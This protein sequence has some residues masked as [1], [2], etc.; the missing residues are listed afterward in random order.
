MA[1]VALRKTADEGASKNPR[2]D[3]VIKDNSYI[4]DILDSVATNEEAIGLTKTIDSIL[5][6][7][8][9]HVKGWQSNRE[10]NRKDDQEDGNEVDVA[11]GKQESKVL[12]LAWNKKEDVLK[13][14]ELWQQGLDWDHEL[15]QSDQ[16]KWLTYFKEMDQLNEISLKRCLCPVV[17][18]EPPILCAFA[19][20]SR[21]A[22]GTCAY[23]RSIGPTG[24][25]NVRFVA[26]KSRVAPLKELT[27]PRLELQA[28][29]LASRLCKTIQN[30]LLIP[31]KES[32]LF[33]DS[34]IVLAWI[35]SQGRRP[36]PFVSSRIGEIESNVQPAQ[37]RHI[38]TDQN[39]ADG[40]SRGLR[41]VELSDIWKNGPEFLYLPKEEWPVENAKPDAKEVERECRRS[42]YVGA[43]TTS[44]NLIDSERFSS[45]RKLVRVTAWVLRAKSTLLAK[46]RSTAKDTARG[47]C[48][49]PAELERSRTFWIKRAQKKIRA[50]VK[51]EELR[52][53]SPFTDEEGTVR[54]GGRI[55]NSLVSYE[56][57]H[58]ALLPYNHQISKLIVEEFHKRGHHGVA[59][60]VAKIR[61]MYWIIRAHNLAKSIK[62]NMRL[63]WTTDGQSGKKQE[64]VKR[65]RKARYDYDY[66]KERKTKRKS[67]IM[68]NLPPQRLQ[69]H[70]PPFHYTAC[71]YFGPLTVKARNRYVPKDSSSP[72]RNRHRLFS[73][74]IYPVSAKILLNSEIPIR[75]LE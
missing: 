50:Q 49:T 29:V 68:A 6:S 61:R 55:D 4:D 46:V 34:A 52:S 5:D 35:R 24:V 41:V 16:T 54:V 1:Q 8:G 17:M 32:V 53:L 74:G 47:D 62:A 20:A 66:G 69:P 70:S 57:K 56:T 40:V 13:Y 2:A 26:A 7:G 31:L 64:N 72:P 63:L 71:D 33:T 45:L 48:L 67:Q 14:K 58:P 75:N 3:K 12:G 43:V 65:N 15:L 23:L 27:I 42:K 51:S 38:P 59:T 10:L 44:V 37:W 30:E 22:F 9:F 19:D 25:V 28:A 39:V 60:T 73:D 18:I 21:K 36:K 11:H